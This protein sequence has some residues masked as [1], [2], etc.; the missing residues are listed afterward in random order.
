MGARRARTLA[1]ANLVGVLVVAWAGPAS[2]QPLAALPLAMLAAVAGYRPTE[3]YGL[4]VVDG[5]LLVGGF[6]A[7]AWVSAVAP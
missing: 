2:V 6:V 7:A 3:R 5:A 4:L 1:A